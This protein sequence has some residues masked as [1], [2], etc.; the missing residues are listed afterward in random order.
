ML[1]LDTDTLIYFL[2]GHQMV[3]DN[4][5]AHADVPKAIS[6][7]TYGELIYGARKSERVAENLAKIHR[8][9]ELFPII[10][11]TR[12]VMDSF[13]EIKASLSSTGITVDDFDLLIGCTALTLN[14]GVVTNNQKHYQKIPGLRVVNWT[15]PMGGGVDS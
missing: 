15:G 4:F 6:A 1:M 5:K 10:D 14:Y 11:I 8:L 3:V 13:G 12:A 9:S 2:K 7:V